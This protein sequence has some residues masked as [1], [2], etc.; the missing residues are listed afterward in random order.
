MSAGG[1][2]RN[3]GLWRGGQREGGVRGEEMEGEGEGKGEL[4]GALGFLNPRIV[5][6]Y[7]PGTSDRVSNGHLKL[8]GRTWLMQ[9]QGPPFCLLAWQLPSVEHPLN[10]STQSWLVFI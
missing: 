4:L 2:G 8:S 9:T 3:E 10:W 5:D 7:Y 6:C 1:R